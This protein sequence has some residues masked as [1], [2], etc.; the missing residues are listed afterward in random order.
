MKFCHHCASPV[1]LRIPDGDDK[2]RH[3]CNHCDSVFYENP[4]NVVGTLPFYEDK[5]LLC[6]RAIQPRL[7]KWTLPAGFM[8]NGETSLEGAVRETAEEAGA[9]VRIHDDSLYT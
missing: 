3:C 1:V 4:K 5:I 2:V 9:T 7:G 8:E 6:K